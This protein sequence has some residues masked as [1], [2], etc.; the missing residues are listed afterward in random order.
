MYRTKHG[1]STRR[2]NSFCGITTWRM[3]IETGDLPRGVVTFNK[4]SL[5]GREKLATM[6]GRA[7]VESI[8]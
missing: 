1:E 5:I 8:R 6:L 7:R 2:A 4:K 3:G